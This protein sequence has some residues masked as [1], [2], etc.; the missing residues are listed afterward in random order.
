MNIKDFEPGTRVYITS[1]EGYRL[2]GQVG[3]G[4]SSEGVHLMVKFEDDRMVDVNEQNAFFF[5][6]D[7]RN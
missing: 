5:H 2:Y 3:R 1:N 6:P 7:D 4:Y